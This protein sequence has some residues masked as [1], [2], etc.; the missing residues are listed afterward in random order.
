MRLTNGLVRTATGFSV[1]GAATHPEARRIPKLKKKLPRHLLFENL[2][3]IFGY[4]Q[5]TR[6]DEHATLQNRGCPRPKPAAELPKPADSDFY[7]WARL[8]ELWI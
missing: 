7:G 2:V 8:W 1:R 4:R 5:F 6:P 3:C